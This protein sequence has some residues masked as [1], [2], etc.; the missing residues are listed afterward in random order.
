MKRLLISIIFVCSI[1]SATNKFFINGGST[2]NWGDTL[3]WSLTDG[4]TGSAGVPTPSD[5][6]FFTANSPNCTVDSLTRVAL[7][8]DFTGYV[9]TITMTFGI[10]TS[11]SI[12][13][14]PTMLISGAGSLTITSAGTLTSNTKIWPNALNLTAGA[15]LTLADSWTVNGLLTLG[16][17]TNSTVLNGST[18]SPIGGYRCG[19]STGG[20]S[21]TTIITLT[22]T[23]T[24]DA[25]SETTGRCR[26]PL[27]IN[28][29][30]KTITVSGLFLLDLSVVSYTSGT[31][32][33]G[34]TWAGAASN[35][36]YGFF[37]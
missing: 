17:S 29:P 20:V 23:Q 9:N 21:G 31:V 36:P 18:L 24:L 7:S 14:A 37:Q 34:N 10:S 15:T 28:A 16:T 33:A 22:N 30:G 19:V 26:N 12:T 8:V 2:S 32:I 5:A 13:L 11:G 3:N 25:P 6:A 1:A 35:K 4:G 27:V